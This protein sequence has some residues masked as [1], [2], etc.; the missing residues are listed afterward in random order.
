[1]PKRVDHEKRRRQTA[2]ALLR[3]AATCGL[4]ATGMREVAAEAGVSRRLALGA[5]ARAAGQGIRPPWQ[6]A[7]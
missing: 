6:P 1:M 2:G 7:R 5:V 3:T 4:H